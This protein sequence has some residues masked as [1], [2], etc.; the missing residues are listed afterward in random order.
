MARSA[1]RA[2]SRSP[3]VASACLLTLSAGLSGCI[4]KNPQVKLSGSPGDGVTLQVGDVR[5]L[6]M[7]LV[8]AGA[9]G[10]AS[11][12]TAI[13][14]RGT[15]PDRLTSLSVDGQSGAAAR[16]TGPAV[17]PA[18]GSLVVGAPGG[19]TAVSLTGVTAPA[20]GLVG[21]TFTFERAGSQSVQ[22]PV[23]DASGY[24][25][26]YAP[27]APVASPAAPSGNSGTP[28]ATAP[29]GTRAATPVPTT[30][31]GPATTSP[32]QG[33]GSTPTPGAS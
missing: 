13:A 6:N 22:V 23:Y 2:W 5:L 21:L 24:Y 3:L 25:S 26:S 17:V 20:G 8:T 9:G 15:Q 19:P 12:S 11:L 7:V 4:T 16:I 30:S 1:R 14:N 28:A 18:G 27:S 31:P 32:A 29:G 33:A 10:R